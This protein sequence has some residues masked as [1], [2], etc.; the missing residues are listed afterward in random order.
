MRR[1]LCLLSLRHWRCHGRHAAQRSRAILSLEWFASVRR[2]HLDGRKRDDC[3]DR[4]HEDRRVQRGKERGKGNE[5]FVT[6]T[7]L[8]VHVLVTPTVMS[9]PAMARLADS[10]VSL[11]TMPTAR[12][13]LAAVVVQG[14][15]YVI[16]GNPG[17]GS[18]TRLK[19]VESYDIASNT[20]TQRTGL[21]VGRD[22]VAAG[23][24][25]GL[26]YVWGGWTGTARVNTL[27][28]Y[29]I[30]TDRWKITATFPT[31]RS[32]LG[33]VAIDNYLYAIGGN[34]AAAA[35]DHTVQRYSVSGGW[36]TL[37]RLITGRQDFATVAL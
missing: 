18:T 36:T 2:G 14:T 37:T 9:A 24:I 6:R 34:T 16:G 26:I 28:Q 33:G 19:A 31:A 12:S 13:D 8:Q 35:G 20:W 21:T 25:G 22:A 7:D 10:W 4:N 1:R 30:A 3:T 27:D 5:F 17:Y 15:I 23:V 32:S 11:A 29:I